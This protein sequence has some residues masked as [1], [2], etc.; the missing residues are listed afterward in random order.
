MTNSLSV[1]RADRRDSVTV[2]RQTSSATLLTGLLVTGLLFAGGCG[3]G[4]DGPTR[5]PISGTITFDGQPVLD[6][7][8]VFTPDT[9]NSGPA[10]I[11]G[12]RE[13][14]YTVPADRGVVGG[15]YVV[16]IT[17]FQVPKGSGP[18]AFRGAP[19]FPDYITKIE[20][21]KKSTTQDFNVP[22]TTPAKR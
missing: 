5:Y 21:P 15:K 22:A 3:G 9:G 6:G 14:K 7:E 1:T 2:R 4:T 16:T 12:I 18:L 10:T 8:I 19:Q 20:L 13:S 11:A 17:G